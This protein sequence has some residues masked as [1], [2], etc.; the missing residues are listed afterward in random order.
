[1]LH[2]L[3]DL[4]AALGGPGASARIANRLWKNLQS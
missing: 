1:M 4:Q 3:K 2:H